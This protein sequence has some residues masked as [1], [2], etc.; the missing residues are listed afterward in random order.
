MRLWM[1]D[2]IQKSQHCEPH[3]NTIVDAAED[4]RDVLANAE[5]FGTPLTILSLDFKEA[6]EKI[7]H[8]YLFELL[9]I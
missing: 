2:I 4:V 1:T 3:W 7:S 8:E 6:F 9:R 5:V